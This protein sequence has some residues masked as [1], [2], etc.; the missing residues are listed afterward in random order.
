VSHSITLAGECDDFGVVKKAVQDR[1]GR[2]N[3]T[4][5]FAP[6]LDGSIGCHHGAARFVATHDNLKQELSTPLGK[7]FYFE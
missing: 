3:V 4:Q 7:L 6:I 5:K 1:R 2:R